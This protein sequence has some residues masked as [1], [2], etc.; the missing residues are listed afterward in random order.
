MKNPVDPNFVKENLGYHTSIIPKHVLKDVEPAE[1]HKHPFM[2]N[3]NVT[4]GPFTPNE[5]LHDAYVEF[6]S[7]PELLSRYT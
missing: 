2:E 1:L 6:D 3:P 4:S 7:N 5:L